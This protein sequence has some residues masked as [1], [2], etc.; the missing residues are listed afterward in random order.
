MALALWRQQNDQSILVSGPRGTGKTTF[1]EQIAA[2][3]GRYFALLSFDR[4]TEIDPLVGQIEL[5]AGSTFWRDGALTAALRRPGAIILFDEPDVAKAGALA[6][7][8]PVLA[9]RSILIPRTGERV[10][11]A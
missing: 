9:N 11:A 10:E 2:Y 4:T 5:S 1:C 3:L 6:A 8:H 7:L